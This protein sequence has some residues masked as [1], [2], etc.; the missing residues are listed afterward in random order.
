MLTYAPEWQ[1]NLEI[2]T[3]FVAQ[4]RAYQELIFLEQVPNIQ[5][6]SRLWPPRA[7]SGC[8]PS[9]GGSCHGRYDMLPPIARRVLKL[10]ADMPWWHPMPSC[11][12]GDVTGKYGC[13]CRDVCDALKSMKVKVPDSSFVYDGNRSVPDLCELIYQ[14]IQRKFRERAKIL[15]P[16]KNP[17]ESA[18]AAMQKLVEQR[19]C[20]KDWVEELEREYRAVGLQTYGAAP[21]S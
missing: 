10:D 7:A 8:G 15:H 14:E 16:D 3:A 5:E 12:Q 21:S 9:V 19:E 4:T 17:A 2:N 1:R 11:K 20:L 13:R 6:F 18:N